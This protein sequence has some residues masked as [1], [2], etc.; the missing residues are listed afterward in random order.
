[1]T[2]TLLAATLGLAALGAAGTQHF[3]VSAEFEP[4]ARGKGDAAVAV[5]FSPT[6]PDLKIN[7][8][9]APRL[10]LD[11]LQSVLEDKQP[12]ARTAAVDPETVK[13]LD[14]ALPVRFPV[15]LRASAK[16]AST[17]KGEVV[18]FYCSKREGWCR[19]GK[20]EVEF[21]VKAP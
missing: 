14:L 15:A 19:R 5:T 18:Y 20:T 4:G 9:P 1:M 13:A 12:P 2:S 3:T 11:P 8:L 21:E 7:E 17:V 10:V 6:A 16:G